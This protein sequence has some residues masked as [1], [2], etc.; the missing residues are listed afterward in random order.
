MPPPW[1]KPLEVDRLAGN[2]AVDFV[3]PIAELSGLRSLRD[4][5]AGTVSGRVRF[6]RELGLAT[7]EIAL[8]GT[9]TL[10]CQRCMKPMQLPLETTARVALI[11]SETDVGRVP[12]DLEPVLA[13]GGR[14][15]IGELITEELLLLLPI[16]PLHTDGNGCA[17]APA[18]TAPEDSSETHRPFA[19][20]GE[21]LKR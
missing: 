6:G 1:S 3:I 2:E 16:V 13:A 9:V 8:S 15:S 18:A 21:L 12:A 14:I 4:G 20:L 10:E 11:A 17:A 7:A 19:R 5:V